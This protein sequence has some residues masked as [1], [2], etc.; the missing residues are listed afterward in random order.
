MTRDYGNLVA[1]SAGTA[2]LAVAVKLSAVVTIA[3]L[4]GASL[5]PRVALGWLPYFEVLA[6]RAAFTQIATLSTAAMAAVAALRLLP[7]ALRGGAD[8]DLVSGRI[9][10]V[11]V[12]AE[13]LGLE[14]VRHLVDGP[15]LAWP[16]A[17]IVLGMLA[18]GTAA[19]VAA[20]AR[21]GDRDPAVPA[22]AR[23]GEL[24]TRRRGRRRAPPVVPTAVVSLPPD[25]FAWANDSAGIEENG[26][27]GVAAGD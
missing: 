27:L 9:V 1:A 6:D 14:Y 21:A 13:T 11:A 18:A 2:L 23:A 3:N 15:L 10:G 8:P 24:G 16:A 4:Q 22:A 5:R 17:A 26:V 12:A 20:A 7:A 25:P 19:G